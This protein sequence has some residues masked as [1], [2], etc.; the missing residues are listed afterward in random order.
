MSRGIATVMPCC[1]NGVTT[2]KM[3]SNTNMMSTIGV[4]L[5]SDARPPLPPADM[6]ILRKP[7]STVRQPPRDLAALRSA[8]RSSLATL[9]GLRLQ[10]PGAVL[11]KVI[12]QLRRRIVHF[13]DE[14]IDFAREIVEQ[15]HRGHGHQQSQRGSEQRFGNTAGDGRDTRR[16]SVLHAAERVD[17]AEHCAEQ[18]HEGSGRT[19]RRQSGETAPK[20]GGL[21]GDGSLQRALRG[22]NLVTRDIRRGFVSTKL[23]QSAADHHGQ[24]R[25]AM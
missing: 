25:L 7:S 16:F 14:A 3:I 11:N 1:R 17:D 21:D 6:P 5:I 4:T 10:L 12:N 18:T 13:H 20:L 24:V 2:M 22:L 19:D 15:P 9:R 23:L 8:R